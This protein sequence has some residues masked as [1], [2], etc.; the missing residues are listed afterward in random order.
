MFD[1]CPI[2]GETYDDYNEWILVEPQNKVVF[3][4]K[5][6]MECN[7]SGRF[8]TFLDRTVLKKETRDLGVWEAN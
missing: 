1:V 6:C 8:K 7:D 3:I 2:C 4:F 5:I